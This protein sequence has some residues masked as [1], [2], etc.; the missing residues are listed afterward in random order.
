M[1]RENKHEYR[2]IRAGNAGKH[3]ACHNVYQCK[4]SVEMP[5]EGVTEIQDAL[6]DPSAVHQCACQHKSR[7]AEQGKGVHAGIK[8]LGDDGQRY[9]VCKQIK[10]G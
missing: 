1:R 8:L 2:L 5:Q 7:N 10:Q 3:H 4:A 9:S 6:C